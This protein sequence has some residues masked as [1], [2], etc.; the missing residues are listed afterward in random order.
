MYANWVRT[1]R[2][3]LQ[4]NRAESG[5]KLQPDRVTAERNKCTEFQ[6]LLDHHVCACGSSIG[7]TRHHFSSGLC[8][9]ASPPKASRS[10]IRHLSLVI[11]SDRT[12]PL[13]TGAHNVQLHKKR[14]SERARWT[15]IICQ[16]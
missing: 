13:V 6:T 9:N 8:G 4:M 7:V 12:S 2:K 15:G 11:V 1:A 14:V 16:G 10:R 3:L 5:K